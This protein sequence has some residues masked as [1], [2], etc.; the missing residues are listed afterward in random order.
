MDAVRLSLRDTDN[1]YVHGN[2]VQVTSQ[3]PGTVV[4]ITAD[5]TD[6]VSRGTPLIKLDPS[7]TRIALEQARAALGQ[8]VRQT[9]TIFVQNQALE[10]DIGVRT[11]DIERARAE[12]EK[13]QSDLKRRQALARSGGV[14]GEEILHAQTAVKAARSGLA[15]AEAA[16]AVAA[17]GVT[18]IWVNRKTDCCRAP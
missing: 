10:A 6:T 1:A 5:E 12:L 16:L 3:I 15:Q 11:A 2:L 13:A 14:S 7:D 8:A 18:P 4:A 17:H 9:R